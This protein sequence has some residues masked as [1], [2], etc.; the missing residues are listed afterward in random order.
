VVITELLVTTVK[1]VLVTIVEVEVER[2]VVSTV[3]IATS[4]DVKEPF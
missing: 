3:V 2:S 4:G 1:V